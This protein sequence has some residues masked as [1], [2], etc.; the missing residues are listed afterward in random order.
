MKALFDLEGRITKRAAVASP[1]EVAVGASDRRVGIVFAVRITAALTGGQIE[2]SP[3]P[4]PAPDHTFPVSWA[5]PVEF[6]GRIAGCAWI[7]AGL[8][9]GEIYGVTEYF[10]PP[11]RKREDY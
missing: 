2:V 8:A 4:T 6:W 7:V 9:G 5:G 3:D 1:G 11:G 10:L